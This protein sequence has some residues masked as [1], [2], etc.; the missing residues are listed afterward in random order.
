MNVVKWTE[1]MDS[2]LRSLVAQHKSTR[3]ISIEMGHSRNAICGRLWRLGIRT[4][5][6]SKTVI[7]SERKQIEA[8]LP[9]LAA[10]GL[11]RLEASQE[12]TKRLGFEVTHSRVRWIAS[13]TG[14]RFAM[15]GPPKRQAGEKQPAKRPG[16][17]SPT[18]E[19]KPS[20]QAFQAPKP[21][22]KPTRQ[23]PLVARAG[24]PDV[25]T[26]LLN[27]APMPS[28]SNRVRLPDI[29][30]PRQCKF[31]VGDIREPGAYW[32]GDAVA[33]L[34]SYC[35][36]HRVITSSASLPSDRAR[37]REMLES[38][39]GGEQQAAAS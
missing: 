38:A 6:G 37:A 10:S 25:F 17:S 30:G 18:K 9:E 32:C 7:R 11:T 39:D 33:E 36:C 2:Q 22:V 19:V 35:P 26:R 1:E 4:T 5:G 3:T 34:S 31:I 29:P 27:G 15:G 14:V 12:L 16:S 8:L 21:A 24:N 20:A 28:A 23:E 13:E